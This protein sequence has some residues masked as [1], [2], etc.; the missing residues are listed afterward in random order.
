MMIMLCVDAH[1][2]ILFGLETLIALLMADDGVCTIADAT[3]AAAAAIELGNVARSKHTLAEYSSLRMCTRMPV[4]VCASH[5]EFVQLIALG[6]LPE[7][8]S[9]YSA[10]VAQCGWTDGQ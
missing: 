6:H 10:D 3:A 5:A 9:F 2:E 1:L 8:T 7:K 4:S